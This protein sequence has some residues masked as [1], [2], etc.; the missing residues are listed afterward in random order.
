ML[1]IGKLYVTIH[2]DLDIPVSTIYHILYHH[3]QQK[4]TP[5]SIAAM[6]FHG[7]FF[8]LPWFQNIHLFSSNGAFFPKQQSNRPVFLGRF[9]AALVLICLINTLWYL[10]TWQR[11][12]VGSCDQLIFLGMRDAGPQDANSGVFPSSN[13]L[14]FVH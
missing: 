3:P 6:L 9:G 7:S 14:A 10:G 12:V 13:L 2:F 8:K 5:I 11:H 4:L 1:Y